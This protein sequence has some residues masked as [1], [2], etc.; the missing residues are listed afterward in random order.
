M[1]T[2]IKVKIENIY[3]KFIQNINKPIKARTHQADGRSMSG[4]QR[5]SVGLVF[6]VLHMLSII[7]K[8]VYPELALGSSV[9]TL[10]ECSV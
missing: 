10:I 5:A 3:K 2:K 7:M 4:H 8:A 6:G 9:R 1:L